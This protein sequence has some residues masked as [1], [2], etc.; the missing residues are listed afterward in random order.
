MKE[1]KVTIIVE[2]ISGRRDSSW[3]IENFETKYNGS[4]LCEEGLKYLKL[5]FTENEK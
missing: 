4:Y 2:D 1:Y 3:S 5:K